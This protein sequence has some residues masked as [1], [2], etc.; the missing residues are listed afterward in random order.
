VAVPVRVTD[1]AA[2]GG[3]ERGCFFGLTLF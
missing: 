1:A 3:T 2:M